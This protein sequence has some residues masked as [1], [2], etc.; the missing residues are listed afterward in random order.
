[1]TFENLL[2]NQDGSLL[3]V[4]NVDHVVLTGAGYWVYK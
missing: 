3:E 4:A 1:M 2:L